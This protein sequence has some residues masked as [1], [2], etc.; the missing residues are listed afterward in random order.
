MESGSRVEVRTRYEDQF[1]R[2][3][4][5]VDV[6][7]NGN[8]PPEYRVRRRSDGFVLPALFEADDVRED[9]RRNALW[10]H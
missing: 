5:I 10:W 1:S 7:A 8:G 4:E 6:V 9:R 3:F 2:G